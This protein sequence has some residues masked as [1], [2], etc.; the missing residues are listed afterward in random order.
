M[1]EAAESGE[2]AMTTRVIPSALHLALAKRRVFAV[3]TSPQYLK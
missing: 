1:V 2:E 3:L